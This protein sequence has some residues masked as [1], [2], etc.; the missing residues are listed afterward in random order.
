MFPISHAKAGDDCIEA[1]IDVYTEN[2][3]LVIE[4]RKGSGPVTKTVIGPRA[5]ASAKA[6][7]KKSAKKTVTTP[8]P[9]ATFKPPIIIQAPIVKKAPRQT[10]AR[11]R[12][13][14]ATPTATRESLADRLIKLLPTPGLRYQP[15][16]EPLINMPVYFSSGLPTA[17]N[18]VVDVVGEKVDVKLVPHFHY[19]FGDGQSLDT[20]DVGGFYPHDGVTHTYTQPGEYNVRVDI[21]WGGTFIVK[22]AP[23]AVRGAIELVINAPIT[24]VATTNRFKS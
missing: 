11:K 21:S 18:T 24:V 20:T 9:K 16:Y 7:A 6:P 22:G 15:G 13:V 2:G 8:K 3:K 10:V 12:V 4:G 23:K 14:K 19:D 5:T 17:F 1:C